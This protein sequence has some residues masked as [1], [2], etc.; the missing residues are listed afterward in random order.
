M[1]E[2]IV[3]IDLGTTN[4]EVAIVENGISRVLVGD[5][6]DPILPSFVGLDSEGKLLVGKAAKNA[7]VL[8]PERTIKSIKRKMGLDVKVALGEREFRPQEISALILKALKDRAEKSLGKEVKKA[9]ITVPAYFN[10]V[11]RQATVEAGELAGL[12]VVRILNEPTAATLVYDP[13]QKERTRILVYD[14]GGGTFDVSVVQIENGIVEV[15]S[16]HGDTQ[17]GG[18]DFDDILLNKICDQFLAEHGLDLREVRTSKARVLRAAEEAKR[19]L[20]DFV[21]TQIEEEFVGE[22]DGVPLHLKMELSRSEYE[23]WLKPLIDRTMDCVQR[24]L[25]DAKLTA[26][27]IDRVVLVGGS[28]RTPIISKLLESRLGRSPHREINPDLCVAMGAAV[29]GAIIAGQPIDSILVDITP[30]T[31]G[32]RVLDRSD[33]FSFFGGRNSESVHRFAPIIRRGTPLPSSRSEMYATA[34]DEQEAVEIDIYQGEYSDVRQNHRVGKFRIEGLSKVPSGNPIVVQ[35][36]LNLNG[37]LKVTAKEKITDLQKNIVIDSVFSDISSDQHKESKR[38]LSELWTDELENSYRNPMS[39]APSGMG[40]E[41]ENSPEGMGA[42]DDDFVI[43]S[44]DYKAIPDSAATANDE[45]LSLV[46]QANEVISKAERLKA[47]ASAEDHDE[48]TKQVSELR[49]LLEAQNYADIPARISKLAD[50]LFYID[51]A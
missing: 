6:G 44:D 42:S 1:S 31:L 10:D 7:W 26:R 45:F 41:T 40:D 35:F 36:D 34:S 39:L 48:I 21:E 43:R 2:I 17:L 37:M 4:S 22:K 47:K 9:V 30:H 18:D 50:M 11:Q 27:D 24:A 29:Q 20:S 49:S 3:G 38:R 5:D 51:D 28:T 46:N 13:Q 25:E 19:R 12:E 15:L 32:I 14:L 23:E 8:A 33:S 16:S